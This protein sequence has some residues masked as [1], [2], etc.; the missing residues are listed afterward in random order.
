MRKS[1]SCIMYVV[2]HGQSRANLEDL[3]GLDTNL[4]KKGE[5]QIKQLVQRLKD[6]HFD[7]IISSNLLRARQSA[8]IISLDHKLAIKTHDALRER[9][10]GILEGKKGS[11]I[12]KELQELFKKRSELAYEE[13]IKFKF[14]EDYESDEEIMSRYITCL[15]ELAIAYSGKTI[16]IVSHVTAMK[17]LLLHLGY[18]SHKEFE[19]QAIYNSGYIKLR[20]DGIDFVI[21]EVVG[22]KEGKLNY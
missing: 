12:R 16:L 17:S 8:E 19:G 21:K 14:S 15:R 22:K 3:Y 13:R 6:I 20:S 2:R 5:E 10:Y 1:S 9:Y 7:A 11:L 4:T 18:A